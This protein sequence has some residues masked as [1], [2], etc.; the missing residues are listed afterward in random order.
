MSGSLP[1]WKGKPHPTT[2]SPKVGKPFRVYLAGLH[3]SQCLVV[4]VLNGNH[5]TGR[6][7]VLLLSNEVDPLVGRE[8]AT[9]TMNDSHGDGSVWESL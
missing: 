5:R 1:S 2:C 9:I 6:Y 8:G 4:L 7:T 3:P